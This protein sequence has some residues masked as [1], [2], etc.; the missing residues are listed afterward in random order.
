[1]VAFTGAGIS[2][3]SGIPD[4]RGPNGLWTRWE[5]GLPNDDTDIDWNEA[6][7]NIGHKI[8]AD[9]HSIGFLKYIIS[10]NIDNLHL[11]SGFPKDALAELHGNLTLFRCEKCHTYFPKD[12]VWNDEKWGVGY[13]SLPPLRG[14]PKCPKCKGR[15]YNSVVNFGE[16]LP[17]EELERSYVE[18]R[19]ADVVLVIGSSLIVTPAADMPVVAVHE[20]HADLIIINQQSTPLDKL[21]SVRFFEKAGITLTAIYYA[22]KKFQSN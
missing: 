3:E 5:K 4:F 16:P 7:P 22:L 1:M 10:Q 21:A 2:T 17:E 14:Q 15:I 20:N 18:I 19:K 11:Q 13:R 9:L 6:K 8:L 12:E